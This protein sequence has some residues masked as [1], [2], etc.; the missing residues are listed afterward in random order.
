MT[1]PKPGKP[2]KKFSFAAYMFGVDEAGTIREPILGLY[3]GDGTVSR[4]CAW[5]SN[6][7]EHAIDWATVHD[8]VM[9]YDVFS[10]LDGN[11]T[12]LTN[13]QVQDPITIEQL[14]PENNRT[15]I[16]IAQVRKDSFLVRFIISYHDDKDRHMFMVEYP[17]VPPSDLVG[18][19]Y[20]GRLMELGDTPSAVGFLFPSK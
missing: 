15:Q 12:P 16:G 6:F 17:G 18:K 1:K 19:V 14:V 4:Y 20:W 3:I 10:R 5:L 11:T 13:Y 8:K 7:K 2:V 9:K